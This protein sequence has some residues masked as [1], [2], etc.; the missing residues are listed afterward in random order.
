MLMLGSLMGL[1]F[2]SLAVDTT[3]LTRGAT[4]D[5]DTDPDEAGDPD[6]S[7]QIEGVTRHGTDGADWLAGDDGDDL[8]VGHDGNDDLHGGLGDDT[9]LGGGGT[10]WIYGDDDFG[11]AGNDSISGGDGDDS[12]AGQGG[13]DTVHGDAGND[14]IFGGDGDD[15]L[16]G[17]S[18]DDWIFGSAGNDTLVAGPG[19]DDL[20]GG[21]GADLLI[22]SAEADR[23]WLHGD[24]GDDTLLGGANDFVEGGAGADLFLLEEPGEGVPTI[25]DYNPDEDRIELRYEDDGSGTLLTLSLDLDDEGATVIRM[26]GV[27]MGRLLDGGGLDVNDILLTAVQP[28]A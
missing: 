20:D 22:G 10:D 23:A 17:G 19:E 13:N 16:T 15:L 28:S 4:Q 1:L 26:N 7:D 11:E 21:E 3:A 25:A 18:G 8:L 9:L 24:E 6:H 27:A 5:D 14:S 12:L 2:M